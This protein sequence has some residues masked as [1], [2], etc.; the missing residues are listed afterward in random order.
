MRGKELI[1]DMISTY[2]M[3]ATMILGVMAVLGTQF[4][5]EVR[6]GYEAF[7]MPLIYA[8]YGTLPNVVMYSKKELSMKQLVIRKI[9]Q[10][11]L[12]E[13][14]VVSVALPKEII[15]SGNH[16]MITILV[17]SILIIYVL[18]HLIDWLQNY[19]TAK[20]MTEELMK[21]QKNMNEVTRG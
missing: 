6:F 8:A 19:T 1:R 5:P 17:I 4:M 12:V 15:K 9:I 14:I 7:E 20:Q 10:L 21:F 11:V 13:I 3:L 2:F 18:T 16:E